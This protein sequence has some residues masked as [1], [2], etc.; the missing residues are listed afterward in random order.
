MTDKTDHD[1]WEDRSK[2]LDV[3]GNKKNKRINEREINELLLLVKAMQTFNKLLTEIKNKSKPGFQPN[4]IKFHKEKL[5]NYTFHT[6]HKEFSDT[7]KE[8]YTKGLFSKEP[9]A[10]YKSREL[11]DKDTNNYNPFQIFLNKMFPNSGI[12]KGI[13]SPDEKIEED[14]SK[15]LEIK[16]LIGTLPGSK[17]PKEMIERFYGLIHRIYGDDEERSDYNLEK[18]RVH[19]FNLFKRVLIEQNKLLTGEENQESV[20]PIVKQRQQAQGQAEAKEEEKEKEDET[21]ELNNLEYF[22]D[23][24]EKLQET[25][26]NEWKDTFANTQPQE[27]E[28]LRK[29]LQK[30][31]ILSKIF[32]PHN[33]GLFAKKGNDLYKLY[34]TEL[35]NEN[36]KNVLREFIIDIKNKIKESS[37]SQEV[38]NELNELEN[39]IRILSYNLSEMGEETKK[40]ETIKEKD[41]NDKMLSNNGD[42]QEI[43]WGKNQI[44]V[45]RKSKSGKITTTRYNKSELD[46]MGILKPNNLFSQIGDSIDNKF[47]SDMMLTDDPSKI[48]QQIRYYEGYVEM[49]K[50]Y[51]RAIIRANQYTKTKSV[52]EVKKELMRYKDDA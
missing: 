8:Q 5:E 27:I 40:E 33:K 9:I 51:K 36:N 45:R 4:Q 31:R 50:E 24:L 21:N 7:I 44:E 29:K 19:Y 38:M 26:S 1:Y 10:S 28:F 43:K 20:Y 6:H 32:K 39:E 15:I 41:L 2:T 23:Y 42:I 16:S 30:N 34:L 3:N 18:K 14:L 37:T 17:N 49:L 11:K 22:K 12:M 47:M 52:D 46:S 13:N 35:K 48:E 25:L